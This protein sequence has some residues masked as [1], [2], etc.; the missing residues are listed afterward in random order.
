MRSLISLS[1]ANLKSFVRDRAALFWTLAFPILFVVLFGTIFAGGGTPH[2]DL[3]WVDQDGTPAAGQLRAGFERSGVITLHAGTLGD[4]K[5]AMS[6]GKV[7]GIVV[8]PAGTG[9][10]IGTAQAGGS[11]SPVQLTIYTDPTRANTAQALTSIA[12]AVAQATNVALSGRPPLL[13][14]NAQ[15]LQT[16]QLSN[17]SYFVPS[18]LAM[19][20][21]QLGVFAAIP[22]VQQREKLI[23]KRLNATPLPRWT[24]RGPS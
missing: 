20:L 21:M 24:G 1:R 12:D 14:V 6:K 2:Y 8:V 18:I 9:A 17:V 4:E 7:A 15:S 11:A 19:A 3:G 23:L 13:S 10:A 5:D 22:L 16:N